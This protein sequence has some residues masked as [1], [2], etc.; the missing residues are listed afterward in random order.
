MLGS[1]PAIDKRPGSVLL[2]ACATQTG[3]KQWPYEHMGSGRICS[4]KKLLIP[5]V[6]VKFQNEPALIDHLET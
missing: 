1:Q 4:N 3:Y 2:S 6:A 5:C